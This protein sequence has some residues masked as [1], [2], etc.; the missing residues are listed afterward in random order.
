MQAARNMKAAFEMNLGWR[1]RTWLLKNVFDQPFGRPIYR[2]LQDYSAFHRSPIYFAKKRD[3][4]IHLIDAARMQGSRIDGSRVIEIGTGWVPLMPYMLWLIGAKR[5]HCIDLNRHLL[6]R[7]ATRMIRWLITDDETIE[8]LRTRGNHKMFSRRLDRLRSLDNL[9]QV[10]DDSR[11]DDSEIVYDA[12]SDARR[13]READH[14]VDLVFSN[15]T[16]EH[17]PPG[18]ISQILDEIH[19]LLKPEGRMVHLID[20][21]DHGSHSDRSISPVNFLRY[22]DHQWKKMVGDSIA[23]HNRLRVPDYQRLIEDAS[24]QIEV[25]ESQIN[26]HS[27]AD[28]QHLPLGEPRWKDY[29]DEDLARQFLTIVA[30]R[31]TA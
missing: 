18:V 12:P 26:Q 4:A 31:G 14:C 28:L 23:Y 22:D 27:L 16:L 13:V 29:T 2:G 5:I 8:R 21:S 19:R 1:Q 15:V 6:K 11:S 9:L 17:I 25:F 20:P 24:F 10:L 30:S 7:A 3:Q